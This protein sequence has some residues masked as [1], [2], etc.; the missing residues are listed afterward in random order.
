MLGKKTCI[1]DLE[2]KVELAQERRGRGNE[3]QRRN[4][5][6]KGEVA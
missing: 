4:I 5:T 3:S 2:V 6:R 1:M